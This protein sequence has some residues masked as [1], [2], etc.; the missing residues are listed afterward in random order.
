MIDRIAD[1]LLEIVETMTPRLRAIEAEQAAEKP[2]LATWSIKEILGH[3]VDSASNNHQR[4]VRAQCEEEYSGP[5]YEQDQWVS[6]QAYNE[7][8]WRELIDLWRL[9]NRH[10][11]QVIRRIPEEKFDMICRIGP[12]EPVTFAFLVEDYVAHIRHHLEQI[13]GKVSS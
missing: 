5:E 3:L 8:P 10:L 7:S 12:Y 1:E 4:F 2:R 9:Y 13:A 11:A 6:A